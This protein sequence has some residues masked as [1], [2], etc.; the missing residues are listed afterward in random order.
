MPNS[1][2]RL[3][4]FYDRDAREAVDRAIAIL[5]PATTIVLGGIVVTVAGIVLH[6]LY[7]AMQGVGI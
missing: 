6:T 5:E 4:D 1:F 2:E 7:G 3:A